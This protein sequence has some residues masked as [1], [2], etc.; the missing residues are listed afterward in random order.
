MTRKLI[1]VGHSIL[2]GVKNNLAYQRNGI[3]GYLTLS[4]YA[5]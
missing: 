5:S 2:E 4:V 3:R 1:D